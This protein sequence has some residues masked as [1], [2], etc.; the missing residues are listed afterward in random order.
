MGNLST[1]AEDL[2]YYKYEMRAPGG[3]CFLYSWP[4]WICPPLDEEIIQLMRDTT[5]SSPIIGFGETIDDSEA[6]QYIE[7]LACNV[8]AGKNRLLTIH[9]SDSELVGLCTLRLNRTPN[10]KHIAD[11][12]KGMIAQRHRGRFLLSAA[13]CEIA[14]QCEQRGIE[15]LTLDVRA[16]TAAHH[17][18]E[19]YGF[20]VY[21]TLEDYARVDGQI[22]AGHFMAQKVSDLKSRALRYLGTH[23]RRV[24]ADEQAESLRL[25][26][27]PN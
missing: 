9:N 5:A 10:N 19:H 18:W 14:R 8:R 16:N 12:A 11:L 15:L 2:T 21:G 13:F 6:A 3:S 25:S 23:A 17:V 4:T 7:E 24:S 27:R 22:V 26:K 1:L 20:Y